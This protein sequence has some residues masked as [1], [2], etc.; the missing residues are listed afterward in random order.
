MGHH[1][2]EYLGFIQDYQGRDEHLGIECDEAVLLHHIY[3]SSQLDFC[4][5]PVCYA[6]G[7]SAD[8]SISRNDPGSFSKAPA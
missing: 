7:A 6:A 2:K 1:R 8:N 3:S 5:L 4:I